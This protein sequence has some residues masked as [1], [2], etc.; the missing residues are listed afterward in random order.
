MPTRYLYLLTILSCCSFANDST[1]N[2]IR[3]K[4]FWPV[5]YNKDYKTLYCA[6]TKHGGDKVTLEHVY[7][8]SWIASANGCQ[9]RKTC[10]VDSYLKASSDLHNLWPALG[11]YK[12]SRGN[13]P[14]TELEGE[15]QRFPEDQCDF[16]R[17]KAGV[18]PR[19]WAKGEIARSFLYMVKTYNLPDHELTALMEKWSTID[20]VSK[21]EKLRNELIHVI[22]GTGNEFIK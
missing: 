22:Q 16:E 3:D 20:P 21:V 14:F 9:N 12:S 17:N 13:L 5:L 10:D 4:V 6:V 18:E 2:K 7:P 8:A 1:Y 11:R 15:T 19:D